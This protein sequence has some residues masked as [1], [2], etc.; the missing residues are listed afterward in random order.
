MHEAK[1]DK[2]KGTIKNNLM[3]INLTIWWNGQIPWKGQAIKAH[4]R[5]SR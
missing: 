3:P 1:N 5:I 2:L 4:L